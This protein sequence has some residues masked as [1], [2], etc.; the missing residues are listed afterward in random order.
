M[1][2]KRTKG[3]EALTQ[4]LICDYL[5]A[6]RVWWMRMNTGATLAEHNGKTRMIRYGRKGCA[7]LL[8]IMPARH[9]KAHHTIWIETKHRTKQSEYQ[10]AF[11]EEVEGE[12]HFY[13]VARTLEDVM[14]VI[15]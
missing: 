6:K 1:P 7:D 5:T 2:S 13:I 9:V 10:K 14:A 15:P 4:S 3:P 8:A 12:G 11:Q